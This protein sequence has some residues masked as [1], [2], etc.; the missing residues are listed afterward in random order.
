MNSDSEFQ[1][2]TFETI[3]ND[4]KWMDTKWSQ[5]EG[6]ISIRCNVGALMESMENFE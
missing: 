1:I 3:A 6:I 2:L 5:T 4:G